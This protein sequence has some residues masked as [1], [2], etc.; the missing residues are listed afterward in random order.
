MTATQVIE[1]IN[2]KGIFL[3]PTVGGMASDYLD[4]MIERELDLAVQLQLLDPMPP[5]LREAQGEYK[6]VY[7][8][9]LF[10]AARAG[11]ASG[12]LRTVESAIQIA[13]ATGDSSVF[14]PFSFERA[15]PEIARIQDVPESWMASPEEIQAK[16][17]N[18]ADQQQQQQQLQAMP[19][20]AA[21]LKAQAAVQK[22]GGGLPPQPPG[23]PQQ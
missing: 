20:Q 2:Q 13:G 12:F 15:F 14:D 16:A 4:P 3:A 10:K 22:N 7:T 6:I 19:A 5:L 23:Q 8:S 1:L 21:M 17:K 18:R 11:E 9:P